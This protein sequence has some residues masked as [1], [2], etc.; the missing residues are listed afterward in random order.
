MQNL[1][2]YETVKV[3]LST[4]TNSAT[5]RVKYTGRF[6]RFLDHTGINPDELVR[7]WKQVKYK[8]PRNEMFMDKYTDIVQ[9]YYAMLCSKNNLAPITPN[10]NIIPI[11]SFFKFH[12]IDIE[13]R[14]QKNVYIKYHNR[15]L[16]KDEIKRILEHSSI[17]EKTFYLMMA[18]SGLRPR[19]IV[20]LKYRHIKEDFESGRIPMKMEVPAGIV[21]DRVGNRFTFIGHDG[22]DA[23]KEYLSTR[24]KLEYDDYLFTKERDTGIE[25]HPSPETFANTFSKTVLKLQLTQRTEKGKPK[26]LRLYCLRKYFRNNI[27]V[28][29]TSF[30]KF[31]M[32]RALGTDGHY[33]TRDVEIHREEYTKAYPN[34]RIYEQ[35]N[36][37]L[38]ELEEKYEELKRE[39]E[40]LS[41]DNE[42]LKK[43]R[44]EVEELKEFMHAW[45]KTQEE[46]ITIYEEE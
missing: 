40:Q 4:I 34:L 41:K 22:Y 37:R 18:E 28:E 23:L 33:L 20:Q 17:R 38:E 19:T 26:S 44:K 46:E 43:L 39:N 12:R 25:P 1:S 36:P 45:K 32:G 16:K 15:D 2:Q 6:G 24:E 11:M 29:D 27:K 7:D 31:W 14:K 42:E 21:K 3:W 30:R 13:I 5:T 10:S 9:N 35:P 8:Y